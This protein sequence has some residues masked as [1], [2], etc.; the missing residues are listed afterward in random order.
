MCLILNLIALHNVKIEC[1]C[2]S[3]IILDLIHIRCLELACIQIGFQL[4]SDALQMNFITPDSI[5][6]GGGRQ[7]TMRHDAVYQSS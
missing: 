1:L 6:I 4:M 7:D 2:A 3:M 5:Q